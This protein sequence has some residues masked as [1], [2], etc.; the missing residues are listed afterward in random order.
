MRRIIVAIA[1]LFFCTSVYG[2]GLTKDDTRRAA[3]TFWNTYRPASQDQIGMN[4]MRLLTYAELP[5]LHIYT[6]N[7]QG[8]IILPTD[9]CIRPVLAYSF[10]AP[11]PTELNSS[12]RYWL[13]GYEQQIA[14]AVAQQAVADSNTA[15]KWTTL[16][17]ATPPEKPI[18][19]VDVPAMLQCTWDQ[20]SPY[21]KF[22]PFDSLDNELTVVGCTATAMAQLMYY[23]KFPT[24]GRSTK[25]YEHHAWN[26]GQHISYGT[27]TADFEHTTYLWD[28]MPNDISFTANPRYVNPVAQLSYHCGIAVEMSYGPSSVG[29]S[30]AWVIS[31]GSPRACSEYAFRDYF[32]YDSSMHG[33]ERRDFTESQWI[34]MIDTDIYNQR[35]ILYTGY[36]TSAGHAFVLDGADLQGRY[37]FNWGWGGYGNGFYTIDNL[38]PGGSGIGGNATY[39]FNYW[40][41]AIFNLFP[42]TE[43]FDTIEVYD[44]ICDNINTYELYDYQLPVQ[45]SDY[46]LHHLDTVINLHLNVQSKHY[47]YFEPNGASGSHRTVVFCPYE[48][49]VMPECT[50]ELEGYVFAGWCKHSNGD[51]TRYQAGDTVKL[52]RNTAFYAIWIDSATALGLPTVATEDN[53]VALWPNPATSGI[54]IS[55]DQPIVE[56][57]I[58]DMQGRATRQCRPQTTMAKIPLDGLHA[59]VYFIRIST[60]E[61]IYNRRIIKR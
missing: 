57:V 46:V 21:N 23:W 6:V 25:S 27:L 7:E 45:T 22:C 30:G 50:F 26:R 28:E 58:Y 8:F 53:G 36:D 18:T 61:G 52:R 51:T 44:T 41:E 54:N 15:S 13:T 9:N 12:L 10:D 17:T 42:T 55:A 33:E 31:D 19:L 16:L 35:P 2:A 29:G 24:F 40:Q 38:N 37:H 5:H 59:G 43:E 47:A 34:A 60:T 14:E 32:K 20:G 4:D 3:A 48:D 11:F 56:V 49:F 39:T 1:L